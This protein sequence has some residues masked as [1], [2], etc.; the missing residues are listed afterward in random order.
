VRLGYPQG[1]P[2]KEYDASGLPGR[3]RESLSFDDHSPLIVP[4]QWSR[5]F[6]PVFSAVPII[7]S[8]E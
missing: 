5:W 4:Q 2:I 6:R 3:V 7:V 8:I 1:S